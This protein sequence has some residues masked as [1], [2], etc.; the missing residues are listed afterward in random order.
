MSTCGYNVEPPLVCYTL[1]PSWPLGS[2]SSGEVEKLSSLPKPINVAYSYK[3][4]SSIK[5]CIAEKE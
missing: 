1:S 3:T 4:K 2:H 5:K